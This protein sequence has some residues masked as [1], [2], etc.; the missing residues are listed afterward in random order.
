MGVV[1]DVGVNADAEIGLGGATD[2][3]LGAWAFTASVTKADGSFS[4]AGAGIGEGTAVAV[5]TRGCIA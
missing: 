5:C 3:S 4:R 2:S 1:G